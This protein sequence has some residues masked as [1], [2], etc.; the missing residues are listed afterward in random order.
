MIGDTGNC[1]ITVVVVV[2][3]PF[4]FSQQTMQKDKDSIS[5]TIRISEIETWGFPF[6]Y[7]C[8]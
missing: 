7:V 4:P 3:V 2:V 5:P 1:Y 8:V 6:L